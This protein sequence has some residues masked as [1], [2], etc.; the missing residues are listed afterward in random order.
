ML[1]QPQAPQSLTI[2]LR[3]ILAGHWLGR[4]FVLAFVVRILV[5]PFE[6]LG[7]EHALL[8]LLRKV[9]N[10]L[11]IG[12]GLYGGVRL[13]MIVQ[14]QLLWR[15]RRR[16]VL[17]YV[18]MG[19]VPV[20]LVGLFFLFA[21]W[22]FLMNV[23]SYLV[24]RSLDERV[25]DADEVARSAAAE[26]ADNPTRD[27]AEVLARHVATS[28]GRYPDVSMAV[29]RLASKDTVHA[30]AW[31]HAPWPTTIPPHVVDAGR[32]VDKLPISNPDLPD[33]P[34][35]L[36]ARG[37]ACAPRG[38]PAFCAVADIPM[39]EGAVEQL[40]REVGI[41]LEELD[42]RPRGT[43]SA[44]AR[45]A[46]G[47]IPWSTHF[48]YRDWAT[49][50][51]LP[52]EV[53]FRARPLEIYERMAEARWVGSQWTFGQL[54]FLLLLVVAS[55]FLV[56]YAVAFIMGFSLARSI[57]GAIH[58]LFAA[59]ER[60][61]ENDFTHR[62]EVK[63]R[64]QLG[65]LA[66]SFNAMTSSIQHLL[67][68]QAEK[69]RLQEELRIARDIQA[70]LLPRGPL[71]LPGVAMAALCVPAREIGGDY[72][73]F[74]LLAE[75]RVGLLVADV[76]GKGTSAALYMAEL[77][78]LMLALSKVYRSPKPLLI[79]VNR[80]LSESLDSR[81]FITMTY[82]IM[83]LSQRTLTYARA[84]HTPLL[85][86]LATEPCARILTPNGL[87]LGLRLEGIAAKF[88]QLLEEVIVPLAPGDLCVLFTDGIT[89]AMNGGADLFGEGR[90]CQHLEQQRHLPL[91]ELREY[92]HR[93][94]N[95]W[96]GEAD[97]HDD[98]TM[99]LLKV[100]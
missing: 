19:F 3:E 79:E 64:D 38:A 14:R 70:S 33:E 60:I 97:Q 89:E 59:T 27:P 24:V 54:L 52:Q 6:L 84:G 83:D 75:D 86:L 4:L 53:L 73:D 58:Q 42:E 67:R 13:W 95:T 34:R 2:R 74:F 1:L 41:R 35:Q 20:L 31:E 68:E 100:G 85:H 69:Q 40:R 93:E 81:S 26:I 25:M 61:R 29:V 16:L 63:T 23:G 96:V 21:G 78:G 32:Y 66:V 94:V 44:L 18:L 7:I 10:L 9:A 12:I 30:G 87:V 98:M 88:E 91:E 90:L 57:T 72:Y 36:V 50:K 22:L 51:S 65:E 37:A 56:I 48:S 49:G 17:S 92:I 47:R 99:I 39:G 55:M 76:S 43:R 62:V 8:E 5:L 11:L 80:I 71:Q 45:D 82:A 77:K 28:A 46:A 15:V